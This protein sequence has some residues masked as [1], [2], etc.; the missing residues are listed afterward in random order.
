MSGQVDRNAIEANLM[1]YLIENSNVPVGETIA[2]DHT[3]LDSG[4]LDSLGIAEITEYMEAEFAIT[5]DEDEISATHYATLQKLTDFCASKL[6]A[7]AA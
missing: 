3:L 4:I 5:I 1:A 6:A 2:P 7:L